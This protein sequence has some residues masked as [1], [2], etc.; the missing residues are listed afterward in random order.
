MTS[1][2][3]DNE[4]YWARKFDYLSRACAEA[5]Y[6]AVRTRAVMG[7]ESLAAAERAFYVLASVWSRRWHN[8]VN[9]MGGSVPLDNY[10]SV[11][12][13]T[14]AAFHTYA[15]THVWDEPFYWP[16]AR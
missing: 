3:G 16:P 8:L 7:V 4:R 1:E 6:W 11:F 5:E 15:N 9:G 2:D 14:R 13:R 10:V 12:D